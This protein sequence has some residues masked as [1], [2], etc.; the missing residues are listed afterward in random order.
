MIEHLRALRIPVILWLIPFLFVGGCTGRK[1][2]TLQPLPGESGSSKLGEQLR[3]GDDV[4]VI[5]LD[6]TEYSGF[7]K[8]IN[9]QS[10]SLK[11]SAP[12]SSVRRG[13]VK[14]IAI[15]EIESITLLD[16]R[17]QKAAGMAL[18]SVVGTA[19]VLML[20]LSWMFPDLPG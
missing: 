5:L 10:I 19:I 17:A 6:G 13:E 4:H 1:V 9:E 14:I 20:L 12:I 15:T 7:L 18:T 3:L 8:G 11:L 2:A 16:R